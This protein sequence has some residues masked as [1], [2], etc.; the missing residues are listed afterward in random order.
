MKEIETLILVGGVA[1]VGYLIYKNYSA[2]SAAVPTSTAAPAQTTTN[3][4]PTNLDGD[5]TSLLNSYL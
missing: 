2:S 1:V 4:L 5:I 3:P